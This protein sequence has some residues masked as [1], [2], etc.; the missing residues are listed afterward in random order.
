MSKKTLNLETL[1]IALRTY[2]IL[3]KIELTLQ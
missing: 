3:K 1:F 2:F